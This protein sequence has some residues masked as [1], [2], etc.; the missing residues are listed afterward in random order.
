MWPSVI[1]TIPLVGDYGI[2]LRDEIARLL[3]FNAQRAID[4]D[5]RMAPIRLR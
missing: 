1:P 2:V 5:L 4:G 3:I